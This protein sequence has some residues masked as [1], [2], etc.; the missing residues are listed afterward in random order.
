MQNTYI[1]VKQLF[2]W[3]GLKTEVKKFVA[4]CDIY[5]RCKS[6]TVAYPSLLQ[7]LP[8][9]N[10]AW[11]ILSMDFI[12]G[13]PKSEGR[14]NT[15]VVVDRLTKFAHFIGLTHPFTTQDVARV[16]LDQ[17]VKIHGVPKTIISNRDKIFTNLL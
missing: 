5:Q 13:L 2:F 15:L 7:P 1:R 4:A 14:G 17:V 11:E 9:L 8:I 16:F 10:Q 3:P 12:E 6:E